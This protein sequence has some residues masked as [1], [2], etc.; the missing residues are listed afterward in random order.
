MIRLFMLMATLLVLQ[1]CTPSK[2]APYL[3]PIVSGAS[4]GISPAQA[5]ISNSN[6]IDQEAAAGR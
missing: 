1:G 5:A 2:N 6:F 4:D 3:P